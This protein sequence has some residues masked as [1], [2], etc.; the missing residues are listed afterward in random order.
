[1]VNQS[2]T[3]FIAHMAPGTSSNLTGPSMGSRTLCVPSPER[4]PSL[5]RP[6]R[7][8]PVS[9][10]CRLPPLAGWLFPQSL[11]SQGLSLFSP[12]RWGCPAVH[13]CSSRDYTGCHVALEVGVAHVGRSS[14]PALGTVAS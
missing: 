11:K 9:G 13:T 4:H 5:Q 1:M 8:S 12:G 6:F 2:Q 10:D 14:Q 3:P 7:V